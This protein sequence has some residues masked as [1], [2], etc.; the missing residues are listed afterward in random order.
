VTLDRPL[1]RSLRRE[2]LRADALATA[3][4]SLRR[5]DLSRAAVEERIRRRGTPQAVQRDVIAA[6][7][8]GGLVDDDRTAQRR[9]QALADRGWGDCALAARLEAE[10]YQ[11][12]PANAAIALLAPEEERARALVRRQPSRQRALALLGRR[13]FS[14]TA[15]EAAL[16]PLDEEPPPGVGYDF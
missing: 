4:R 13:G 5:R 12:E 16:G 14:E 6:L 7:E 3:G 8:R 11:R 9:A 15:I 2:L 1:L 10:G